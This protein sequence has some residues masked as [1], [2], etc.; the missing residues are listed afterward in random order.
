MYGSEGAGFAYPSNPDGGP[1]N[2]YLAG[3]FSYSAV[4]TGGSGTSNNNI[5]TITAKDIY[6]NV[7]QATATVTVVCTEPASTQSSV[8]QQNSLYSSPEAVPFLETAEIRK[9]DFK[10]FPNPTTG[11]FGVQLSQTRG[12]QVSIQVL[13]E[14]G[15]IVRQRVVKAPRY[16]APLKENFDLSNEAAGVYFIKFITSE[17]VQVGKIVLMKGL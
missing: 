12:S 7:A 17:G 9:S 3:T 16:Q 4:S 15:R 2:R 11:Q 14:S 1:G 5:V 10:V 13:T 8:T 6:G